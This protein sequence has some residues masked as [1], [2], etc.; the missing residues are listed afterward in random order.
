MENPVEID[1]K[2]TGESLKL[3]KIF[4]RYGRLGL[5]VFC[6]VFLSTLICFIW[7]FPLFEFDYPIDSERWGQLGDFFGGIIGTII[8]FL[9]VIF[10]YKA[11]KEQRLANVEAHEVNAEIIKQSEQS[12]NLN[13]LQRFDA[14]YCTLLNLYKDAIAGYKSSSELIPVGKASMS[15]LVSSFIASTPFDNNETYKKRTKKSLNLFNDFLAKNMTVV[16]AHMRILY[17]ILNLLTISN[18]DENDKILYAKLLRSQMTD[19]ELILIRYNCMTIRGNKMQLLVFQYNIL[20][21]LPLLGLFE[22]KKYCKGLSRSQIN[23]INDEFII[24]RKDICRQFRIQSDIDK[25]VEKRYGERYN[26]RIEIRPD[27]KY[28]S[29]KMIKKQMTTGPK[30]MLVKAFDNYYQNNLLFE[31]LLVDFHSE[32]FY[33]SGF[34]RYNRNVRL[35]HSHI[36][37][38]TDVIF[39]IKISQDNPLILSYY[40]IEHPTHE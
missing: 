25:I 31:N 10:L 19:E 34:K 14:N 35:V 8:T 18:I 39:N 28:Y 9:S 37:E 15:N 21:H 29:F 2:V 12:V 5:I 36:N 40:Q 32:L 13:R 1:D 22:F 24:W 17:Q 33:F 11:F 30:D 3:D 6:F 27:N 7:K 38:G 4:Y 26:L 16:N 20:K 23:C